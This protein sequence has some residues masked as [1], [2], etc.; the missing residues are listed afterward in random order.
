MGFIESMDPFD[1][2]LQ[3]QDG[4]PCIHADPTPVDEGKIEFRAL[5]LR[6]GEHLT[7]AQRLNEI[8]G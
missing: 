8:L 6:E 7:I 1:L 3:L 2:L 5:S 4:T